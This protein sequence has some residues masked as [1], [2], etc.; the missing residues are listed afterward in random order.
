[1]SSI[2]L[3]IKI[4]IKAIVFYQL[5]M[6]TLATLHLDVKISRQCHHPRGYTSRFSRRVYLASHDLALDLP[7][8]K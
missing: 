2:E 7:S 8:L 5:V 6:A 3:K 1:M 4:K